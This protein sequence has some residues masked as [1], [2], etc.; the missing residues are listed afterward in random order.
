MN[1]RGV[2]KITLIHLITE[3]STGGAQSALYRLLEHCNRD[4]F[5]P[6]VICLYGGE[7]QTAQAIRSLDIPIFDLRM[8]SKWRVD[9]V[10]RVYKLLRREQPIILHSW[11]IHANLLGRVIGLIARI[12]VIIIS[13]RNI[14]IG[15]YWRELANRIT[16][17]LSDRVIAVCEAV[18][19]AEIER[20]KVQPDF[21]LTIH[22]GL[23]PGQY[24]PPPTETE[25]KRKALGLSVKAT[26]IGTAA[27][28][29]PQ[30]G[31]SYLLQAM[32]QIVSQYPAVQL[33]IIGDGVLRPDLEKQARILGLSP[34]VVFAGNRK[35][36]PEILSVLDIFVLPSLWEGL[37]NAVMEAMATGLPVVAT[38]VGGTPELIIDNET[39]YLVPP[40]NPTAL[41][42]AIISLL[43]RPTLR[44]QMGLAGRQRIGNH[45]TISKMVF[46]MEQLY[47]QLL[48]QKNIV[49][50]NQQP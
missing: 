18:R 43:Q 35:D 7:G 25:Q 36:I 26:V 11:M 33:L 39:G 31:I 47:Q 38:A 4:R 12:P 40:K 44:R 34:N 32:V 17:P 27:R 13:R 30:K 10:W 21:V 14:E 8:D 6:T 5:D 46:D 20:A 49:P 3:L 19:Q 1:N 37:P 2:K 41:A 9:G 22:N 24:W 42:K 15:G 45:F 23:T 29:V 16:S 28:L 50:E 48:D